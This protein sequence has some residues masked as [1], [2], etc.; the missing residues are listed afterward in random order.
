[1]LTIYYQ[2]LKIDSVPCFDVAA[3]KKIVKE[4]GQEFQ[5]DLV[6]GSFQEQHI[7]QS[8]ES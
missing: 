8:Q 7:S 6:W 2:D 1:M 3:A 4:Y 5:S